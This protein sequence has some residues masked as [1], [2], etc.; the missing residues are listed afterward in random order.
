M[1]SDGRFSILFLSVIC[2]K[3]ST[4]TKKNPP[5][6]PFELLR[7]LSG[8]WRCGPAGMPFTSETTYAISIPISIL[9]PPPPTQSSSHFQ[10]SFHPHPL[11]LNS[12]IFGWLF[13]VG[14]QFCFTMSENIF[15]RKDS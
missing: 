13:L 6:P 3:D 10:S 12:L 8:R 4:S 2:I 7:I 15:A 14:A 1:K 11:L 9:S 5:L